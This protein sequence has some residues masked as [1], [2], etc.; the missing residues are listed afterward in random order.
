M[1]GSHNCGRWTDMGPYRSPLSIVVL[2]PE[3]VVW[4]VHE[5][6]VLHEHDIHDPEHEDTQWKHE[7]ELPVR[8]GEYCDKDCDQE[9]IEKCSL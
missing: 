5:H 7:E 4:L 3:F 6:S 1:K 9:E 2:S 8:P